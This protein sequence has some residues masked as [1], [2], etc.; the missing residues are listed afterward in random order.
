[1]TDLSRSGE[2]VNLRTFPLGPHNIEYY[3]RMYCEDGMKKV[4]SQVPIHKITNLNI[5]IIHYMIGCITESATLHQ[6]SRAQM[7]FVA[8]YLDTTIFYW[9]NTILSYMKKQQT[10][11]RRRKNKKFEFETVICA[12]FLERVPSLIPKETI[13]G[14]I[15]SFLTLYKWA[16]LLPQQGTGRAQEALDGFVFIGGP[17][18][19]L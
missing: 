7:H 3:I 18:K 15:A 14:H 17:V 6:D 1:L 16:Y 5:W 2:P 12:L 19:F 8:Q 4:G 13:R 10:D 11:Y 9:S